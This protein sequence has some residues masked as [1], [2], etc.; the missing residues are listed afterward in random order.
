MADL[1]TAEKVRGYVGVAE[2][3]DDDTVTRI[4]QAVS[5][6]IERFCNQPLLATTDN[7]T[8]RFAGPVGA[9]P[10]R[11]PFT[12]PIVALGAL[13]YSNAIGED[14]TVV[15]EGTYEVAYQ[16]GVPYV[17]GALS[18]GYSYT[19]VLTAGY[20]AV[21]PD[22]EQVCIEMA[23]VRLRNS[24]LGQ[25]GQST[26]GVKSRSTSENGQITKSTVYENPDWQARL[27]P[28]RVITI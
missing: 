9:Y 13:S 10:A 8:H 28:Y 2:N 7:V 5:G 24:G 22:V 3:V 18:G 21:P 1:T 23:A 20:S 12:V 14:P 19:L 6:E 25:L 27:A 11:L 26:L 17:R 16:D 15:T 4:I